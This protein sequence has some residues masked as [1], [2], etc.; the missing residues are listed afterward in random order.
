M[1]FIFVNILVGMYRGGGENYDLNLT[2]ELASKGHEIEF[3]FLRPLLRGASLQLPEYC[4]AQ[5]VRAP[6]LYLW[7]QRLHGLPLIGRIRGLRGLPRAVGQA[8]FELHVLF[9]LWQRR[10][11]DF[12]VHICG[13][14]FLSMLAT[15]L[16]GNRVFVR[17]PG[18]PSFRVHLWCL[19]HT[20]A[21]IANGD[22]Y[23]CIQRLAPEA[24]LIRLNVGVDHSLFQRTGRRESAR[25]ELGLPKGKLLA[26]SV[27]RFVPI[28]N[29][30][31]LIRAM[32]RVA[33]IR[34]DIDLVLVG[35]G[36]ERAR[37]ERLVLDQ[38]LKARIH[39]LNEA[40]AERL[41]A[42]YTAADIF[43]LSSHYDN[44]PNVVLE[45]MSMELPVIA[46]KVGGVPSQ[47]S[48]GQTGY[49]VGPNDD[50]DMA[51]QIVTMANKPDIRL[52]FGR[53]AAAIIRHQYDWGRT[54]DYFIEC[55]RN[56]I[57]TGHA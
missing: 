8:F 51:A 20:Y 46:T 45:A 6:W 39:F 40:R 25:Q 38:G 27:G 57:E 24:N 15:K 19:K 17:F 31:M 32:V 35:T 42:C 48:I 49:L 11:E 10:R 3:Y 30:Q 53:L 2:R 1:K 23:N 33:T 54:A 28:K 50:E 4:R 12:I 47:V 26:L 7:T 22:A 5:P 18:P 29:V 43:V 37:I 34:S 9:R 44:F 13:L 21:V 14:S 52:A 16:L 55:A 56:S 36:P 41:R